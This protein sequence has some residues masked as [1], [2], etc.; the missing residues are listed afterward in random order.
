[1]YTEKDRFFFPDGYLEDPEWRQKII[2]HSYKHDVK[3]ACIRY[4]VSKSYIYKW[5][6]RFDG[7]NEK[8]LE[9][10]SRSHYSHP[11]EITQNEKEII[12]KFILKHLNE[13]AF[14]DMAIEL[15]KTGIDRH[16]VTLQKI[17]LDWI[18]DKPEIQRRKKRI[19]T[20]RSK[21]SFSNK[22]NE[23]KK[24]DKT[25]N[26]NKMQILNKLNVYISKLPTTYNI[27]IVK[28]EF[29]KKVNYNE[30]QLE[31]QKYIDEIIH[32]KIKGL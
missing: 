25:I 7:V 8:S 17:W 10:Q 15:K 29:H 14:E 24:Y 28:K 22:I 13:L 16:Y 18:K 32:E 19:L 5:R 12:L 20:S 30:L 31:L 27:N 1:M 3:D 6:E 2:K 21:K 11:K 26:Q 4:K 23:K 9:N